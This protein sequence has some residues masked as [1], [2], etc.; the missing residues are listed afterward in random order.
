MLALA[1]SSA[2]AAQTMDVPLTAVPGEPV[3]GR[4]IVTT[5]PLGL[6]LL[7]HAG[8]FPDRHLHGS[9]APDLA[10]VGARLTPG[11]IRMR[12]VDPAASNPESIMP[13]YRRAAGALRPGRAFQG[14]PILSDQA[15][16]DVVAFL[17]TLKEE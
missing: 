3:R 1:L 11:E 6:C 4:A 7:C 9:I 10:G 16:E 15:I 5:R 12:L 14:K 13:S 17:A 8:P 2:A